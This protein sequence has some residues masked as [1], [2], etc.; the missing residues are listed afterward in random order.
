MEKNKSTENQLSCMGKKICSKI[1]V[2][3]NHCLLLLSIISGCLV[4]FEIVSTKQQSI[5]MLLF[6][7]NFQNSKNCLKSLE[8]NMIK[9]VCAKEKR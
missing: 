7:S 8:A 1:T 5:K 9:K 6:F 2:K 3:L 4:C